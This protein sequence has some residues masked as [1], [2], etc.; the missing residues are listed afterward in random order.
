M[1]LRLQTGLGE[2]LLALREL[3]WVRRRA[4]RLAL[5][6]HAGLARSL[7]ALRLRD[8]GVALRYRR[9]ESGSSCDSARNERGEPCDQYQLPDHVPS[10]YRFVRAL[11]VARFFFMA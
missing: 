3:R 1:A 4:L 7:L 8:A 9:R 5:G 6:Y 2:L 11:R 10:S